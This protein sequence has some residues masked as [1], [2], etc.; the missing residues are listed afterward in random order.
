MS[1]TSMATPMAAS[2]ETLISQMV[3]EGWLTGYNETREMFVLGNYSSLGVT[4]EKSTYHWEK[5]LF[6]QL[7]DEVASY[8][9]S[10]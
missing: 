3:Q 1:G 6:H 5:V 4:K 7:T 10:R 8:D 2:T 9:F